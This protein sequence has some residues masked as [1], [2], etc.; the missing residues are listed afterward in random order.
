MEP[1]FSLFALEPSGYDFRDGG[2]VRPLPFR[3]ER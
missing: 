1:C 3:A 2:L